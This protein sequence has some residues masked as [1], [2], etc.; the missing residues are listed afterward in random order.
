M[1]EMTGGGLRGSRV[2]IFLRPPLSALLPRLLHGVI[3][4]T[5]LEVSNTV[6]VLVASWYHARFVQVASASAG[7]VKAD[8]SASHGS[9]RS[10]PWPPPRRCRRVRSP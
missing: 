10:G 7:I 4:N 8:C 5:T 1:P 2:R 9:H 6:R 3:V